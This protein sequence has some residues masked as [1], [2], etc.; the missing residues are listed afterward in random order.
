MR[1][2]FYSYVN[3]DWLRDHA[4]PTGSKPDGYFRDSARMVGRRIRSIIDS[5]APTDPITLFRESLR[6]APDLEHP[7]ET[8][9]GTEFSIV[10]SLRGLDDLPRVLAQ[11]HCLGVP[12][13]W[14]L[15]VTYSNSL[16]RHLPK[17]KA[18]EPCA[19]SAE[20]LAK[21]LGPVECVAAA[22]V[23]DALSECLIGLPD[24]DVTMRHWR[25]TELATKVPDFDWNVWFVHHGIDPASVET[26]VVTGHEALAATVETLSTFSTSVLRSWL[27]ARV[28]QV[29]RADLSVSGDLDN[30]HDD[31]DM[32]FTE[33][34]FAPRLAGLYAERYRD[35][36]TEWAVREMFEHIRGAFMKGLDM[37]GL[38]AECN[39][40]ARNRIASVELSLGASA[41]DVCIP[42]I[43]VEATDPYGNIR[44]ALAAQHAQLYSLLG[45]SSPV[46]WSPNRAYSSTAYFNYNT[47][48]LIVP[49]PLMSPPFF[50]PSLPAAQNYGTLGVILG[51]E[52]AHSVDLTLWAETL[53]DTGEPLSYRSD[54]PWIKSRLTTLL[55]QCREGVYAPRNSVRYRLDPA[56]VLNEVLCDHLG[57]QAAACALLESQ[58]NIG[59][60]ALM[61]FFESWAASMRAV[62]SAH[63]HAHRIAC[64]PH[65]PT[66]ARCTWALRNTSLFHDVVKTTPTDGMWLDPESRLDWSFATYRVERAL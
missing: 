14:E 24:P 23:H 38:S 56:L 35:E 2:D 47:M 32:E 10:N 20:Q 28:L 61:T 7:A 40:M 62:E 49:F 44:R 30:L 34:F 39:A 55:E 8:S 21:V 27:R 4:A 58:G 15:T 60:T 51:H 6:L 1:E 45:R 64:D 25:L 66:G 53:T 43:R 54:I 46:S 63:A 5:L 26:V 52:L 18:C 3:R 31:A 11:L 19:F 42:R 50:D 37:S 41:F 36:S 13:A 16:L 65:P 12:G 29:R 17:V 48:Q 22:H 59:R 57:I 9:L 33:R